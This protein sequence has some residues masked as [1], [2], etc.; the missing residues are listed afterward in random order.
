MHSSNKLDF[1]HFVIESF[2]QKPYGWYM[3]FFIIRLLKLLIYFSHSY[4]KY[5]LETRSKIKFLKQKNLVSQIPLS[6]HARLNLQQLC[7]TNLPFHSYPVE[8]H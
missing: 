7:G 6:S 3:V 4:K 1:M 5:E 2:I 8:A